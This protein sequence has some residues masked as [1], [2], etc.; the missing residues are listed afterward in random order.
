MMFGCLPCDA[1]QKQWVPTCRLTSLKAD[2]VAG[3]SSAYDV[4]T[5]P[6]G[7]IFLSD[8]R[9]LSGEVVL[10]WLKSEGISSP[11]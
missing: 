5:L 7:S 10:C 9:R 11:C 1:M 6:N 3:L 8:V 4:R 2:R